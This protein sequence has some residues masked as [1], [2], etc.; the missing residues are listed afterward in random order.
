MGKP[1]RWFFAV[2]VVAWP[3]LLHAHAV[4]A[5]RHPVALWTYATQELDSQYT[6]I[7]TPRLSNAYPNPSTGEVKIDYTTGK[8]QGQV[9]T[10]RLYD[11]LGREVKTVSLKRSSGSIMLDINNLQAGIYF[12]SLEVAG[13]IVATKRLIVSR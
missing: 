10:L 9:A 11:F 6:D 2:C 7:G 5:N 1:L 13:R 8:S 4:E 12:Y 3:L